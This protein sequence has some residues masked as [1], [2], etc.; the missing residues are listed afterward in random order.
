MSIDDECSHVG[1]TSAG[2]P[3]LQGEK[4]CIILDSGS[5][6]SL[7]PM[8]FVADCTRTPKNQNLRDCQGQQLHPS[9][10]K[11]AELVVN[12]LEDRQAI[13]R[14]KFIAGDV[15]N[16]LLS[17]G[18][19]MRRGWTIGKT[20]ESDSGIALISPDEQLNVPVEYKGDSLAITAWLMRVS[21]CEDSQSSALGRV[22]V[23]SEPLW[24][25]AVLVN[26]QD[27]FDLGK[28][29]EWERSGTGTS[30]TVQ[31]GRR[32]VDSRHMW[33]RCWPYR[34][35]LIREFGTSTWELVELSVPFHE[36][37]NYSDPIPEWV[38]GKDWET[39]TIMAVAPH[40]LSYFGSLSDEQLVVGMAEVPEVEGIGD[41]QAQAPIEEVGP[42]AAPQLEGVVAPDEIV[43]NELVLK[44]TSAVRDLRAAAKFLI[45]GCESVWY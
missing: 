34:S 35:S 37:E 6:V 15:T 23:K 42:I 22:E 33:G 19:L 2:L 9:G 26:V 14:Q 21:S 11:D 5:D 7:L 1:A 31:R 12:D 41:D 36:Y 17:L 45:L 27:E 43:I 25:Q 29:R 39:L 20:S 10:T 30:Y 13:L 8:S 16:C 18:Q 40:E 24:V 28:S 44:P 4:S 38:V 32:F 3:Q